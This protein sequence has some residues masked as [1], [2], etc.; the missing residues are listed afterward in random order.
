MERFESVL[1]RPLKIF[2][3]EGKWVLKLAF[4]LD[5][6]IITSVGNRGI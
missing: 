6:S 2:T 5:K 3:M 1:V 4:K